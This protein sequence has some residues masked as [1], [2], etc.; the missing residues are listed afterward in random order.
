MA[1][2]HLEQ[3]HKPEAEAHQGLGAKLLHETMDAVKQG[4]K[5][6]HDF[7]QNHPKIDK[8]IDFFT[9]PD[10]YAKPAPLQAGSQAGSSG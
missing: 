9:A 7:V 6:T 2:K 3:V 5:G 8:V 10:I 1:D 4:Q